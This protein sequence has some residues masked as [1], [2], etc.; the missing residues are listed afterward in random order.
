MRLASIILGLFVLGTPGLGASVLG[1]HGPGTSALVSAQER[2]EPER[3]G[4]ADWVEQIAEPERETYFGRKVARTMH[5]T[6]ASWLLRE[7][8]EEEE[9][10]ARMLELLGV[11]EVVVVTETPSTTSPSS[12]NNLGREAV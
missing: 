4:E 10:A 3:S 12:T 8:R 6:G 5:W 9:H 7:T 11:E 2:Q 1:T